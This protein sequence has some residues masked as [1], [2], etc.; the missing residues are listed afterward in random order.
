MRR[1]RRR[2]AAG[3]GTRSA[4][5]RRSRSSAPVASTS[6]RCPETK[7]AWKWVL[8]TPSIAR[9]YR[10]ASARY[11]VM[12]RRGSTTMAR[13]AGFVPDQIRRVGQALDVVLLEDHLLLPFMRR[14]LRS[15]I[16][17]GVCWPA[18]QYTPM[19]ISPQ[20]PRGHVM[21]VVTIAMA[22]VVGAAL[23]CWRRL[24]GGRLT[25]KVEPTRCS[26]GSAGCPRDGIVGTR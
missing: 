14:N 23:S 7:S 21:P 26:G 11:S 5:P 19:G 13:P 20:L 4:P 9:P 1:A 25:A 3:W 8:I 24:V 16:P 18:A 2:R 22:A 10:S 17:L 15:D 6:S 12:S